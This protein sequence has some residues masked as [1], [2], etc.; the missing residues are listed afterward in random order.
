MATETEE[1][2][3]PIFQEIGMVHRE[4]LMGAPRATALRRMADRTRVEEIDQVV[5]A[6]THAERLGAGI[7]NALRPQADMI[8]NRVWE[9]ARARAERLGTKL[10]FPIFMGSLPFFFVL[11]VLPLVLRFAAGIK[12]ISR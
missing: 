7:A 1:S 3:E 8:R 2:R 6:L 11:V 12:G 4:I 10:L 5:V 9:E